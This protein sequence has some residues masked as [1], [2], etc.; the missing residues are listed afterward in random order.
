MHQVG[1]LEFPFP[2]PMDEDGLLVEFA[3]QILESR[4]PGQNAGTGRA[5]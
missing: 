5:S 3:R 2:A 4:K 1:T